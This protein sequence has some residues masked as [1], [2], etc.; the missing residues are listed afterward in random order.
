VADGN[1]VELAAKKNKGVEP[2]ANP[3]VGTEYGVTTPLPGGTYDA[4]MGS[5]TGEIPRFGLV[6]IE[7]LVEMR[8]KDGQAR[9]L[10]RLLTLPIRAALQTAEWVEPEDGDAEKETEFANL[11]FNT[12]PQN[13]GMTTPLTKILRNTLLA[14]GD[15]YSVFE[16]VRHVPQTGPLKGKITLRKLAYRDS[17]TIRFR[18]DDKG[19]FDGVRQVTSLGGKAIDVIIPAE[20]CWY[21]AANEEENPYYGVS[22]FE[23]AWQHYDIKR[24]LYYIAHLAA[25]FAAVPGRSGKVPKG[26]DLKELMQFKQSLADFAFNTAMTYPEGYEVEFHNNTASFDFLKLIDHHNHMMSRSV[27]AGFLDSEDRPAL[28]DIAKTDP[29]ADMFVMAIEAIMHEIAESW[30]Y[31]LMP[32]YID[33]NFGTGKYPEFKFGKMADSA[34]LAI[35]EIFKTVVN[36][37][38]LNCTPEFVRE[39]EMKLAEDLG[40]DIDYK[41][42]EKREEEAAIQAQEEAKAQA[43]QEADMQAQGIPPGG[44]PPP[45]PGAPKPPQLVAASRTS[46][47]DELVQLAQEMLARHQD[48]DLIDLGEEDDD[49]NG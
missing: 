25:Q 14:L 36:S 16:E 33:W 34:K 37:S 46:D 24:K 31:H 19:G 20:K 28:V 11:M 39:M 29:Q 38:I 27:L 21:Y 18:V 48:E 40:L 32:K 17:R 43:Q 41:E 4:Y 30:T 49:T 7:N 13:G 5:T 26:F 22:V 45:G 9:A 35:Q 44:G 15:G 3:L 47:I 1:I 10:F 23:S 2:K 12:P 42:I 8:R 6:S